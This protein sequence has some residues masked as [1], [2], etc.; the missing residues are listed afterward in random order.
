MKLLYS[1]E[2]RADIENI[3][4]YISERNP[5][6]AASLAERI[7]HAEEQILRF[8]KAARHDPETDAYEFYI[9]Q[10][11]IILIYHLEA[12]IIE[13][14]ATFHTSRDPAAKPGK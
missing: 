13:I 10:T 1:A 8:P 5:Q 9:R 3:L 7:Y 11:H 14:I 12:D 4:T 2:A 6:A